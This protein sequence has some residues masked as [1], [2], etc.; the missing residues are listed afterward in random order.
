MSSKKIIMLSL[1]SLH[2]FVHA[3][4]VD[5]VVASFAATLTIVGT[6]AY[7][8]QRPSNQDVMNRAQTVCDKWEKTTQKVQV[9][10]DDQSDEDQ[11][12]SNVEGLGCQ[13]DPLQAPRKIAQAGAGLLMVSR[14]FKERF[15]SWAFWNRYFV[16]KNVDDMSKRLDKNAEQYLF[17]DRYFQRH[18]PL[19]RS[20]RDSRKKFLEQFGGSSV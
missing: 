20:M 5:K 13:E 6:A 1:L 17:Y 2:A 11:V 15:C 12:K 4:V 7:W 8:S 19:L 10:K 14:E 18:A 16:E 9:D 3:D